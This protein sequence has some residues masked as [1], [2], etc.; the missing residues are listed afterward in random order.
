MSIERMSLVNIAGLTKDLDNTLVN[1][2][3]CGCF[4]IESATKISG[5]EGATK[6]KEDNPYSSLLKRLNEISSSA[7]IEY[8]STDYQQINSKSLDKLKRYLEQILTTVDKYKKQQKKSK[9]NLSAHEQALF[10]VKHLKGLNFD[11][12]KFFQ[13]EHIKVRFGRL[14]VDSYYKL[15][16]YDDK[17]FFFTHFSEDQEYYW[18]MYFTPISDFEDVDKIFDTLYFERIYLP[19]FV[20]GNSD[21]ACDE[22]T[23]YIENDKND[24]SECDKKI[25]EL[26]EKE[27]PMLNMVFTKIKS[28][29]DNFHLRNNAAIINDKF[30]IIGFIPTC[31]QD[32]FVKMFDKIESV[33]LVIQPATKDDKLSPPI[34][35]KNSKF[36]E[37]FS[38]FVEMYGLPSYNGINPTALV[39][40]TYTLLFGIMFGDLGQGLVI[41]IIGFLMHKFKKSNFGAI[42]TRIGLSSA[43]FGTLYG[44]VF[45]FEDWLDPMYKKLGISFLPFKAME[46]TNTVLIGAI[47]LGIILIVISIILN[48]IVGLKN[49]D[50]ERAVFGNNGFVGLIFFLGLLVGIAGLLININIFSPVY[51]ICILV[52]PL[53]IM[54]LREPLG[55]LFKHKKFH[56]DS[57]GDFIASNFFEVF[58]F[59]LGYATNT[60]SFVRIG[61]FVLS[62]AG[63]MSVVLALSESAS[64]G[65]SPI[66]IV[67]GNIFVMAMEGMIVGIQVLRLE[68]YEIFSRFYDGDGKEF[69]PVKIDYNSHNEL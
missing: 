10:Q 46:Q 36:T 49:K 33:S 2:S 5:K 27:K 1:L 21:D 38:M 65:I 64:A 56:V 41:A 59:L 28:K 66:I 4:H 57:V 19:E 48:I 52:I 34:K 55:C 44:S 50:Y 12:Q 26:I 17:V 14:P 25:A 42:L 63:M 11:F 9:D 37:P 61:G 62:H 45:G 54:F 47:A 3:D 60:L 58:E 8:T 24:I 51:I 53:I 69:K 7:G 32:T 43:I 18:G 67:I 40:I 68:F 6:V 22:L 30:Y 16:Y 39:A 35:I 13:C 20:H 29:H 15:P 23:S 31:E